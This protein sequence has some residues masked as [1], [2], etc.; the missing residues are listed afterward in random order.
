MKD[1]TIDN[2]QATDLEIGW[3][4]GIIDGEGYIGFSRQNTKKCRSIRP[5]IQVVNCD[6]DV[7][8]KI[9]KILN[10]F[11]INPYIRER[12]HDKKKWSRNYILSMSRF[13][14][15]K[16][17]IDTIGH[18]LTGEKKKRAELMIELVNSR[19]TKTKSDKYTDYELS[20]VE[21]Y[22]ET[23]KGIKIRGNT[24]NLGSL[25]DYQTDD[26]ALALSKV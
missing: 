23:M 24:H 13:S 21:T 22:F 25:N 6:P 3:L 4:A 16:K 2:Q 12:M 17:L 5:D 9:R 20:L 19:I 15:L 14:H 10:M 26:R 8:L 7:I 1:E 18:L 11:G